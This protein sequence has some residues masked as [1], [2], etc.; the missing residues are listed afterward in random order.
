MNNQI[1]VSKRLK[2]EL[3]KY[4]LTLENC[5]FKNITYNIFGKTIIGINDYSFNH[6]LQ[7]QDKK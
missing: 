4:N 7:K 5:P 3:E 2:K 1:I 6:F